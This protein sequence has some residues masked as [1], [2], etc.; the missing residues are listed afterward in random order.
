MNSKSYP[1][2]TLCSLF[3]YREEEYAKQL[4]TQKLHAAIFEQYNLSHNEFRVLARLLIT[5]GEEPSVLAD[6]LLVLRQTM[7]KVIDSLESK[8]YVKRT[9]HPTDRRRLY[10]VP[11]PEGLEIAKKMLT[12]EMNFTERVDARIAPEDSIRLRQ[13][14][15]QIRQARNDALQEMLEESAAAR[16]SESV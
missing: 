10:I 12:I 1:N 6:S 15:A 16:K 13:L 11:L 14:S 5:Q 2:E 3:R 8:G 7:T 9:V 4:N